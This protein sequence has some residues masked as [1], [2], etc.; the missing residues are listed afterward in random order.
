M[1]GVLEGASVIAIV[2]GVGYLM[3]RVG[4]AGEGLAASLNRVAFYVAT[5]A[6]MF[7]VVSSS[8]LHLVFSAFGIVAVGAAVVGAAIFLGLSRLFFRRPLAETTI[9]AV[10]A[11]YVN[12][13]N[14]G[15]PVAGYVIGDVSAVVA[16]LVFQ[17]VLVGPI[18][19]TVLELA[20]RGR[21]SL[22]SALLQPLR[23]P[24]IP[25]A[26]LGAIV[27]ATGVQ[28]PDVVLEPIAML[29]GASIPLVLLAFGMS[30]RG[31][32][33]LA[34]GRDR[35]DVIVATVVKTLV[36]PAIAFLIA[37]FL[38]RLDDATT[39]AV[40]VV[41]ALPTGQIVYNYASRY[42]R[43]LTIARDTVF[44]STLAA[45]PVIVVAALLLS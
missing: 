12:S 17:A 39:F 41:A 2:I 38:L 4:I 27:A 45:I 16:T 40:V 11:I 35:I 34:P 20:T 22:R 21:P 36:M 6:I 19:L 3:A 29:G 28:I 14:M 1:F 5:P 10:A 18:A 25:A 44:V 31:Q 23:T 24:V 43:G 32:R 13:N 26:V 9:G 33:P 37:R 7:T 15:I 8:E 42:G 30:L